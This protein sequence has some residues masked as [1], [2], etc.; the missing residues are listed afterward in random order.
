MNTEKRL[1]VIA[2][3]LERPQEVQEKVNAVISEF[4]RIVVGRM[5]IPHRERNVGVLSLIVDGGEDEI[6]TLT[7]RLGNIKGVNAKATMAKKS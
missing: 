3:I 2:V 5:G 4:G 6:N 7:G 1:G